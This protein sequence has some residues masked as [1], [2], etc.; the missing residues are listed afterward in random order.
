M[1]ILRHN[2]SAAENIEGCLPDSLCPHGFT[3]ELL[4]NAPSNTKR[5]C[6]FTDKNVDVFD[7]D[8]VHQEESE[9]VKRMKSK[10]NTHEIGE[11]TILT[12]NEPQVECLTDLLKS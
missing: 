11:M 5:G 10:L 9:I 2:L 8:G 12:D 7:V 1:T 3:H 4:V 6:N